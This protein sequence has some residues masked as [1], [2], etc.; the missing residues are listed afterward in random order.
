MLLSKD[1][2]Y[3][4]IFFMIITIRQAI[5]EDAPAITDLT[6]QLGYPITEAATL[7]NLSSILQNRRETVLV[8]VH[9]N[10]VIGWTGVSMRVYL[11]SGSHC[12]INGLVVDAMYHRKGIGKKLIAEAKLWSKEQGNH[13]LRVCCNR[14]RKEAHK[15]YVQLGFKEVKEQKI[16]ETEL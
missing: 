10:K 6:C 2:L 11:V 8:A 14:V 1:Y 5:K 7:N 13:S 12:E 9:E 4:Q 15:F 3:S 16:F